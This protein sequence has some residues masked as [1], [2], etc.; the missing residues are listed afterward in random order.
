VAP[1]PQL[2]VLSV[3]HSYVVALNRRLISELARVGG[4][5]WAFTAVAPSFFHAD[6]APMS[7]QSEEPAAYTLKS[8]PV[9]WS[10]AIHLF[11]YRRQLK[12]L[13]K[14]RWDLVHGW[15][16]PYIVAGG[17]LAWTTPRNCPLILASAQNIYKDYL[18]PFNLIER[19]SVGR[20]AGI[21]AWGH[22]AASTL[23]RRAPYRT[24]PIQIIPLGV[25]VE[26]FRPLP[27]ARTTVREELC[28][29]DIGAPVVGFLGRFVPEKGLELLI[30]SLDALRGGWRALFV[31]NGPLLARIQDWAEK[32]PRDVRI[33]TGVGHSEVPRY[34]NAMDV[35]CAPSQTTPHWREQFG[36]MI[37]EAF[38][39]GIPVIGSDSG[40]IPFTIGE[41]G[42]IV[43]EGDERALTKAIGNLLSDPQ[44][45][46]ELGIAGRQSALK[47]YAWSVIAEQHLLFFERFL[48]TTGVDN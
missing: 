40:E 33:V 18:P 25:D 5:R 41:A 27:G 15:E 36:R 12:E 13:F 10:S 48:D 14:N 9:R 28:W 26:V 11:S 23:S 24:K 35:L 46:R 34:L 29:S 43:A 37:T 32:H 8:V 22:T 45:R 17:Q 19:Y 7:L 38:A 6:L 44:R 2:R 20:S 4:R 1:R 47:R 42:D 39:C 31:G 3:A 16:E 21:V 30:R